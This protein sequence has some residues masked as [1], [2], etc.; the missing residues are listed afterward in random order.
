[1]KKLVNELSTLLTIVQMFTL[2]D[3]FNAMREDGDSSVVG[4]EEDVDTR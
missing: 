1:M 2:P 3:T 4:E